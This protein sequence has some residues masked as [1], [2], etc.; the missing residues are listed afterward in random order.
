MGDVPNSVRREKLRQ[1]VAQTPEI[2]NQCLVDDTSILGQAKGPAS[3][4]EVGRGFEDLASIDE[5]CVGVGN[6]RGRDTRQARS[7]ECFGFWRARSV[8]D[9]AGR[10]GESGAGEDQGP[11]GKEWRASISPASAARRSVLGAIPRRLAVWVVALEHATEVDAIVG[12]IDE[13]IGLRLR[14]DLGPWPLHHI[15]FQL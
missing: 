5:R 10:C 9:W 1:R 15:G 3:D 4:A 2:A 12:R 14:S 13:G 6:C 8:S 11:S 7:L